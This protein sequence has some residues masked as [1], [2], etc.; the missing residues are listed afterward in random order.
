MSE[1]NAM[2]IT[3]PHLETIMTE[4]D[5]RGDKFGWHAEYMIQTEALYAHRS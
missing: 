5:E 4:I 3:Q 2:N 1:I